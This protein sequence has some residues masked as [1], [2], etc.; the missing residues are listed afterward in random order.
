MGVLG[1]E[2]GSFFPRKHPDTL[3]AK[4]MHPYFLVEGSISIGRV[5]NLFILLGKSYIVK[6]SFSIRKSHTFPNIN[7]SFSSIYNTR[8]SFPSRPVHVLIDDF[9]FI[10]HFLVFVY[11][12][13]KNCNYK[14][15][16]ILYKF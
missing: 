16:E 7:K 10:S 5:N 6:A 1:R 12:I 8:N 14:Y 2:G 9:V 13:S 4:I 11:G 3:L 15:K